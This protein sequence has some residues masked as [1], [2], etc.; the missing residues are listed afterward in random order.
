MTEVAS[1][2]IGPATVP[3]WRQARSRFRL[4]RRHP[5]QEL[6]PGLWRPGSRQL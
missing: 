1:E 6:G 2:V 5:A 3:F 4:A